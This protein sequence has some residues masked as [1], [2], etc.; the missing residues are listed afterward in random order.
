[1]QVTVAEIYDTFTLGYNIKRNTLFL[2][3]LLNNHFI[4]LDEH[5][6]HT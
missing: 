6:F 2:V 5:G 4:W 3:I 1:M